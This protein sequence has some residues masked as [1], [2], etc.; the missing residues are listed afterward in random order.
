MRIE[1]AR[2]CPGRWPGASRRSGWTI[3]STGPPRVSRR[4]PLACSTC[5]ASATPERSTT[6]KA[7]ARGLHPTSSG[8]PVIPSSSLPVMLD[9]KEAADGGMGPHGLLIGATGSGKSELL[10]TV[11]TA[12]ALTHPPELLS[13]VL[14]D[15]KGGAAFAGVAGL[16][17]TAGLITN[18]QSEPTMVDRARTALLGEQVRRQRLLRDAG[19]L[20][21]LTRYQRLRA[22]DERLEPLPRLLV[23]VDEF[24]E[25]LAA[26][27]EFLDLFTAI[28]RTGR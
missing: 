17:H 1:P 23:V 11:V 7:G 27:P 28:G 22:D 20:D 9:L 18:L 3:R 19:D 26:H 8:A 6:P 14:V 2:R 24:G 4:G 16:P 25:L 5:S 10:R 15:F 12:L 13:F 21:S